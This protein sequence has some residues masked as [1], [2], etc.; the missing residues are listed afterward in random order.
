MDLTLFD[1]YN[2]R[3]RFSVAVLYALPF[4][5]DV[6]L[7]DYVS[8]ILPTAILTFALV[9]LCQAAM[10]LVRDA[11]K[12][13]TDNNNNRAADLLALESN[14]PPLTKRRYYRKLAAMEPEFVPFATLLDN[15]DQ[16]SREEVS[17][18]CQ[19][20]IRWLRG[21]TRD[22]KTFGLL[23]EENIN[24]G[25]RRNLYALRVPSILCN[26]TA[27]AGLLYRE[28]F[29]TQP[30]LCAIA[31]PPVFLHLAM[32]LYLWCAVTEKSVDTASK[33]YADTLLETIDLL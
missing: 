6:V 33:R 18:L 15:P 21:K 11:G 14:L 2:L 29:F 8:G 16:L 32:L 1:A 13:K 12:K 22:N 20:A 9:A 24:Y 26:L 28:S 4:I 7:L 27:L 31:Q 3:A 25:F 17:A 30:T 10:G 5:V 23:K 19:T